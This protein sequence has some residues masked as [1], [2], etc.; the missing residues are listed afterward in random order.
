MKYKIATYV[1]IGGKVELEKLIETKEEAMEECNRL[2]GLTD[3]DAI[4]YIPVEVED[5]G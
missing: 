1:K 5:A 3:R 2:N 4:I